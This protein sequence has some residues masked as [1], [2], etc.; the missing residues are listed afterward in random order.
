MYAFGTTR[1]YHSSVLFPSLRL[2]WASVGNIIVLLG[3]SHVKYVEKLGAF[4]SVAV[5]RFPTPQ[6]PCVWMF[7]ALEQQ[8]TSSH[9]RNK[10]LAADLSLSVVNLVLVHHVI[11]GI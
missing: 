5:S 9:V 10:G 1:T 4:L 2:K 3:T 8:M 11:F 7:L 6:A